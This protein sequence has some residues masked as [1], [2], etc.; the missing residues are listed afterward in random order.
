[1]SSAW[2]YL[3]HSKC[4]INILLSLPLFSSLVASCLVFLIFEYPVVLKR[5][6][7][8]SWIVFTIKSIKMQLA[9]QNKKDLPSLQVSFLRVQACYFDVLFI[10]SDLSFKCAAHLNSIATC[11]Q[12][13]GTKFHSGQH[14]GQFPEVL[15]PPLF[16]IHFYESC[17]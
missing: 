9:N 3:G 13:H 1:M 6:I 17:P 16:Q 11:Q 12:Y 7:E 2:K 8:L 14:L 15:S 5:C 4:S 10:S